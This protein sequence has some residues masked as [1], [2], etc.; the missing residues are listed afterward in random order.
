MRNHSR[1]SIISGYFWAPFKCNLQLKSLLFTFE[2]PKNLLKNMRLKFRVV[3]RKESLILR[4]ISLSF[5]IGMR[6][7]F[8]KWEKNCFSLIISCRR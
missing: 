2:S 4:K 7:T 6:R 3:T 1:W 8:Q 5:K